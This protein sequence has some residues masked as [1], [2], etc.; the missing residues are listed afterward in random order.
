MMKTQL[1]TRYEQLELDLWQEL[2]EAAA[3]PQLAQLNKLCDLLDQALSQLPESQQ[4]VVAGNAIG[5][6]A[7]IYAR[8]FQ[9]LIASWEEA[10]AELD[11]TLPV[12]SVEEMEAWVRQTMSVELDAFVQQPAIKRQ[13]QKRTELSPADSL[14]GPVEKET[15]LE[16]F[17]S[18]IEAAESMNKNG[19]DSSVDL[20][21]VSQW[22]R[23]VAQRLEQLRFKTISLTELQQELGMPLIEVW[24]GVLLSGQEAYQLEQ[25]GDFYEPNS[26]WLICK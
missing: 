14:A 19:I 12:L 13:R 16:T 22:T 3:V 26:I 25:W 7:Q 1:A 11:T 8:R 2:E 20:E 5:Q 17:D 23:A 21:D 24:L 6:I 9:W 18:Q 10:H 4:L 15:L